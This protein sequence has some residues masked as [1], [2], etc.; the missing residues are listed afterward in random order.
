VPEIAVG[1]ASPADVRAVLRRRKADSAS[2]QLALESADRGMA[3]AALDDGEAIGLAVAHG[4][5]D[6]RYVGE[7][8]VEPSYR[9]L[10]VGGKL[11]DAAL[12]DAGDAAR[13]LALDP[14]DAAGLALALRHGLSPRATVARIAGAIPR[15]EGLMVMAAGD[16]RFAVDTIDPETHAYALNALDRETRGIVRPDDHAKFA[17]DATGQA[18]FLN[19]EFVAYAYVWPDGRIGPLASSSVAYLVQ[20]FGFVLVTLARTHGASWCTALLPTTN[21]RI[22]RAALRAGLRIE[23]TFAIAGDV[24]PPDLANY[25]GYHQFQF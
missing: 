6:E 7:L 24:P 21:V 2:L 12:A 5:D 9:A 19:G 15:E 23:Q 20:I 8:F 13:S 14:S 1:G 17:T 4:T 11:L 3:W 18:F 10:G 22:A 25:V 16:Y